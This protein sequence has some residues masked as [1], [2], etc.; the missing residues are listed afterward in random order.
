MSNMTDEQKKRRMIVHNNT[1]NNNEN[2]Y[3]VNRYKDSSRS[4]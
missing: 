3:G 1:N 2:I 4:Y